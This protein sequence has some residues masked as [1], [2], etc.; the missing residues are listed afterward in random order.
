[1]APAMPGP[2]LAGNPALLA[3]GT[4]QKRLNTSTAIQNYN[5]LQ[6]SAQERLTHG[7]NFQFN[8]TWS[9]A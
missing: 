9:S 3:D 6:M 8:Y 5:G 4:G 1:M 2:Y 7:L